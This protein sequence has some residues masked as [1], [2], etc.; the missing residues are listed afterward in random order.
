LVKRLTTVTLALELHTTTSVSPHHLTI[1]DELLRP[2]ES[3]D[4][5]STNNETSHALHSSTL[6]KE[7]EAVIPAL[8]GGI[9]F[10]RLKNGGLIPTTT[11]R[12]ERDYASGQWLPEAYEFQFTEVIIFT[13]FF[14]LLQEE[15]LMIFLFIA[16]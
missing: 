6:G 7:A 12:M 13:S 5:V 9:L 8:T 1:N 4:E 11:A 15:I 16:K 10:E 14:H 3:C 2:D